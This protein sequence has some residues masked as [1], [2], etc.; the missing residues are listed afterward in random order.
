MIVAI[1]KQIM[2]AENIAAKGIFE[3]NKAT[4]SFGK[5]SASNC[6]KKS[7]TGCGKKSVVN[8]SKKSNNYCGVLIW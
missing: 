7:A 8:C 3:A 4:K 2:I 5:K 6:V 1:D